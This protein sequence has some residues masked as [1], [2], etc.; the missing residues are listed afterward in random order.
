M[1]VGLLG[2]LEVCIAG[3]SLGPRDLGGAKPKQVLEI[4]LVHQGQPVPKDKLTDLIWGER[5]PKD[6]IRTLE[7]YVSGLRTRLD[8]AGGAGRLVLR[9][10][11][12][13]YR[14]DLDQMDVD[15][16]R[17]DRLVAAAAVA[18]I[19]ERLQL[20]T[21]AL[22]LV[23]GEL[24]ADEPYAEWATPLRDLYTERHLHLLLDLAEDCLAARM[25]E[26]ALEYAERVLAAQPAR[27]R[28]YRLLM[29]GH[30]A[31][32]DQDL[33]LKA[34]ER[35]RTVLQE[36]LGVEPL[37][38]TSL[39]D[40]VVVQRRVG[41]VVLLEDPAHPALVDRRPPRLVDADPGQLDRP[42]LE[43]DRRIESDDI[44]ADL[45]GDRPHDGIQSILLQHNKRAS[46]QV[47]RSPQQRSRGGS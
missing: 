47:L 11:P 21:Q 8:L 37:A 43:F 13:A 39:P 29:A 44:D 6:P 2:P 35:C 23:R 15:L 22:G 19:G 9:S 5:L 33:A 27:E 46:R 7:A 10:E 16:V 42:R 40:I 12:R 28:A 38:E 26:F 32:G 41:Q 34:Y 18:P 1:A 45:F 14:L 20:R 36:D 3:R 4:L 24:L 30:Y 25:P 31:S 17:F